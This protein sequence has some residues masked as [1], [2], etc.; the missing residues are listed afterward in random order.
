[1]KLTEK[2]IV[3][4]KFQSIL[5]LIISLV[6][7]LNGLLRLFP[8][9]SVL[10]AFKIGGVYEKSDRI[11]ITSVV[12]HSPADLAGILKGDSL[13]KV[14]N[15]QVTTTSNFSTLM[16]ESA[17]KNVDILVERNGEHL[18][19]Q[20]TPRT[21]FA[22]GEGPLGVTVSD[23]VFKPNS[24]V[25][26]TKTILSRYYSKNNLYLFELLGT[27]VF[28]VFLGVGLL[29]RKKLAYYLFIV[30]SLLSILQ[31]IFFRGYLFSTWLNNDNVLYV[32]NVLFVFI[33]VPVI[34][35]QKKLFRK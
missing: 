10:K 13:I 3:T 35:S 2:E 16:K 1:M 23:F 11:E 12:S 14:N 4:R 31:L 24:I 34:V 22:N 7:I 17:G 28:Y 33:S 6:V 25:N 19:L 8:F 26:I 20:V 21:Q 9:L 27:G 18:I 29:M 5:I 32:V 15:T 30:S